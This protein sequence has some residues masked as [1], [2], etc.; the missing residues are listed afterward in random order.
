MQEYKCTVK[1]ND[2]KTIKN[3]IVKAEDGAGVISQIKSNGLFLV[4]FGKVEER[5]DIVGGN[6]LRLSSKDIAMLCRQLAS[7]LSA[8]VTLVKALD[9]LYLQIE[10][11]NIKEAIRRLY[12][13]VQKGEQF[14][15]GLRKESGVYPEFMISMVEA[16]EG[17]GELD[18]V[19]EKLASHYEKENRLK[20]KIKTAMTY[21][22]ILVLLTL[23]VI[24]VMVTFVLPSFV[25][26]FESSGTVLPLPTRI[27]MG[28][29]S[30]ITGY[31]YVILLV[32][33]LI[34]LGV[35]TYIHT[36]NGGRNWHKLLLNI[37]VLGPTMSKL[38][39]V[40]FTRTLSTLLSSGMNLLFAL[41]ISI[42]V[43]GNR[44]VMDGLNI[45]KEDIRKGMP[46]SQSLRKVNVLP[47]MVSSMVGIGE[48][49][50]SIENMLEK[51]ADYYD[52]EVDNSITKLVSM[53]EPLLII[54]MAVVIG[55]IVVAMYLPI[56]G[57]YS[58]I[59]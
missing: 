53:L 56:F 33:G 59:Q 30:I 5:K 13:A 52:D 21:P 4:N 17:S 29:S 45:S 31:W 54:S 27:V 16:G 32:L 24:I 10:K 49:S 19:I 7:M 42:R 22:I 48:E 47:P 35:R 25:G 15:E 51:C 20:A 23:S 36:E 26:M 50:G 3:Y 44:V 28:L 38:A 43:A 58:T 34:I 12:E 6:R 1:G 14:S 2:G 8:G 9:I 11:K 41:D 55:F 57:S 37:P 18:S 46:L 39:A 40:R